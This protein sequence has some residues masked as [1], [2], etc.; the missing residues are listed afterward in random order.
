MVAQA[1]TP[2]GE[3]GTVVVHAEDTALAGAAVMGT[4]GLGCVALVAPPR[5]ARR[6]DPDVG[7]SFYGSTR[8][9]GLQPFKV[10]ELLSTRSSRVLWLT[11]NGYVEQRSSVALRLTVHF[12]M[13]HKRLRFFTPPLPLQF[14]RTGSGRRSPPLAISRP[15]L[16]G[17]SR[18]LENCD[19]E[20]PCRTT[21]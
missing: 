13:L 6:F 18:M 12:A 11:W 10:V 7:T 3:P 2:V 16:A 9:V 5:F 14:I 1:D 19:E 15:T 21:G 4:V 17:R 8:R 20:T